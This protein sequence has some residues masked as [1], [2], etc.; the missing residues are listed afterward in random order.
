MIT[1]NVELLH[2]C[3]EELKPNFRH[4]Y[5]E[6]ALD[7]DKVPLDPNYDE[8]L[9][10]EAAGQ[11]LTV[12]LREKGLVIGYFVGHI[13]PALNYQTCLTLNQAIFW[14]TPEYRA[15]DSLSGLEE[16]LLWVQLFECVIAEAKR[17]G[18]QRYFF[19]S[20]AHKSASAIFEQ[21]GMKPADLYYSGWLGG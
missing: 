14:I 4:Q 20:K 18:V 15:T 10:R 7:Q 11:S 9:R 2:E 21:M 19:G 17:R 1:A 16:E 8:Y 5:E 3:L 12:T 13:A 6:L